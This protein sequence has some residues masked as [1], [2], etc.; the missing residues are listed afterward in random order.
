MI[1]KWG[2]YGVGSV[3]RHF[4]W[5]NS[6]SWYSQ[7]TGRPRIKKIRIRKT[8]EVTWIYL[9]LYSKIS[10]LL[11]I[12]WFFCIQNKCLALSM[13]CLLTKPKSWSDIY[14]YCFL[15]H[16]LSFYRI[17]HFICISSILPENNGFTFGEQPLIKRLLQEMFKEKPT[18]PKY[19]V[20]YD[21]KYV[22]DYV[23]QRSFS[24]ET[25]SFMY[26]SH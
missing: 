19:T 1:R 15:Q 12:N 6:Y 25:L 3:K 11:P 9:W 5:W 7:C 16:Y 18:F 21:V 17:S 22:L 4:C 26:Q 23:K 8:M 14:V 13:F 20:T 2:E 24:S 10:R